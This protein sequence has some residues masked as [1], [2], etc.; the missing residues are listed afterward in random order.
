MKHSL[1]SLVAMPA[2]STTPPDD[3]PPIRPHVPARSYIVGGLLI[4]CLT[5]GFLVLDF[6]AFEAGFP[7]E[8]DSL[9][10]LHWLLIGTQTF[11][12]LLLILTL[13]PMLLTML[14]TKFAMFSI[15]YR[16]KHCRPEAWEYVRQHDRTIPLSPW[17]HFGTLS[18]LV[19]AIAMFWPMSRILFWK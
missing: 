4:N 10:W 18:L 6:L 3:L 12:G 14:L 9:L 2:L 17:H 11:V 1:R 7:G 15:N 5:A 16:R 8:S 13:P 19:F